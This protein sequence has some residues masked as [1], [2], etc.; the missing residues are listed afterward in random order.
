MYWRVDLDTAR[1]NEVAAVEEYR[2]TGRITYS[3][4]VNGNVAAFDKDDN[5]TRAEIFRVLADGHT[6]SPSESRR[7]GNIINEGIAVGVNRTET[8]Y[9]NVFNL[10]SDNQVLSNPLLVYW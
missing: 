8:G 10:K 6:A 5:L 4:I 3:D 2:P 9:G 7:H 1:L